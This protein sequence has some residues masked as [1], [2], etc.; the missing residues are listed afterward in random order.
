MP[1]RHRLHYAG[2]YDRRS[3]EVRAAAY[4]DPSTIC[5]QCLRTIAEHQRKWTAGHEYDGDA[6]PN[7]PLWPECEECNFTR[8]AIA[9]NAR[10]T[11]LTTSRDW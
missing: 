7:A 6:R 2:P 1:A 4:A 3:A 10:R 5:W 8:G 9:G 11:K